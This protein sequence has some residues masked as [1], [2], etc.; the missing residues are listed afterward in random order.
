MM[1]KS[2]NANSPPCDSTAATLA[3]L[4]VSQMPNSLANGN[5]TAALTAIRQMTISMIVTGCCINKP[6]L[7]DMP[8]AIKNR[9]SN[10]PLKGAMLASSSCRYSES[11]S[12]MPAMNAPSTIDIPAAC[13][14]SAAPITT[15]S[16][17]AVNISGI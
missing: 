7:T 3:A 6:R 13:I 11:A 9:P 1:A 10:S 12:S 15:S 4:F 5:K 2:T 8:T 16:A 17:V 14:K